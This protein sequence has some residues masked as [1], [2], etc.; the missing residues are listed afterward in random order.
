MWKTFGNELFQVL[1][2][3]VYFCIGDVDGRVFWSK[4]AADLCEAEEVMGYT[5]DTSS[6]E[7]SIGTILEAIGEIVN[8]VLFRGEFVDAIAELYTMTS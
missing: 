5:P 7:L 6:I 8:R 3:H 2:A 4:L 1:V